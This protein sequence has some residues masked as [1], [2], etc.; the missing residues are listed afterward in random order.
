MTLRG[1][2]GKSTTIAAGME[3]VIRPH[4]GSPTAQSGWSGRQAIVLLALFLVSTALA[5]GR[6]AATRPVAVFIGDSY[7][8]G[9]G[10]S[11]ETK[12]WTSLVAAREGW[13]ER[14]LARGGTGYVAT[15]D[16][17]GCGLTYCPSYGQ[18]V[19]G[20]A[21]AEPDIV[22]VSGGRNDIDRYGDFAL[23]EQERAAIKNVFALLR[24]ELPHAKIYAVSPI[25]D[26][27]PAPKGITTQANDV[28]AAVVAAGGTYLD[29]GQPLADRRDFL[30]Q[31]GVHPND[32]GYDAIANAVVNRLHTLGG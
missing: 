15:S 23:A 21:A 17:A 31:D 14:N 27:D 11:A 32:R 12:R 22:M 9:Q 3:S 28:H 24:N 8:A 5:C 30:S 2:D 13:I 4:D 18:M 7:A 29:I 19:A 25:W 10:S 1:R 26:D 6:D 16:E 20:L